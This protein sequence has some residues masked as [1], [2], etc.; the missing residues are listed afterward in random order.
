MPL[1]I[2]DILRVTATIKHATSATRTQAV[3][4]WQVSDV[5]SQVFADIK[6]DIALRLGT[7]YNGMQAFFLNTAVADG[8]KLIDLTTKETYGQGAWAMTGANA[9][10]Q[11]T[12]PQVAVECIAYTF[13]AGRFGRK[14]LGPFME[15]DVTNGVV[16]G[17]LKTAVETFGALWN[18]SFVGAAT[19]NTYL[20]G[21][22]RKVGGVWQFKQ[23]A[24]ALGILVPSNTRTQRS[25]TAGRG[26]T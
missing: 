17:A 16:N 3:F 2:N 10:G 5:V 4:H 26:L 6:T 22:A 23:F 14:Y 1:G 19:A 9:P 20:P 18:A 21:V 8:F 7:L 12:S 13:E 24:T 25:R 15:D 11:E